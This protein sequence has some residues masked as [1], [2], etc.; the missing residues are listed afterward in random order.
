ML[1]RHG[2]LATS[3][4]MRDTDFECGDAEPCLVLVVVASGSG[5]VVEISLRSALVIGLWG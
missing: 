4:P 5:G 3:P 1:C 2:V